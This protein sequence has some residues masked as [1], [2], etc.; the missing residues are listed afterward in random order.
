MSTH[1]EFPRVSA[2]QRLID[3]CYA[4]Q[5]Y[6]DPDESLEVITCAVAEVNATSEALAALQA[7]HADVIVRCDA[8]SVEAR[9]TVGRVH[10]DVGVVYATIAADFAIAANML[11]EFPKGGER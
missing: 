3:V 10:A 2:M 1:I 5:F 7:H 11:R 6:K 9:L 8:R 4:G